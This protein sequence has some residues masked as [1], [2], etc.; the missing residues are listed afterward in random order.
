M[1]NQGVSIELSEKEFRLLMELLKEHLYWGW[2]DTDEVSPTLE[3]L[4]RRIGREGR[5]AA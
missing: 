4:Y 3:A 1:K 5:K 2:R